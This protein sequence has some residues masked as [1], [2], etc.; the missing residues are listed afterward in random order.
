M[1]YNL[2]M[3]I[4]GK[5]FL[6]TQ[7]MMHWICGSTVVALELAEYLKSSGA[8]VVIYTCFCGEPMK[9][10]CKERGI[11]VDEYSGFPKYKL[12]DFDVVWVHSQI[13]PLSIVEALGKKEL[14]DVPLFVFLHM[15][16]MDWIPDEKPWI[17][18]LENRLSSLS[19]FISEEVKAVNE[20]MIK[21]NIKTDFF[22]NPA[23][24]CFRKRMVAPRE[25][26]RN[27]LIV[28]NHPPQEVEKAGEI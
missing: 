26:V 19:L 28:S 25:Q 11:K 8:E 14:S 22:R 12:G 23:P 7:P 1:C 3:E 13:L 9:G 10:I 15:S 24:E 27:V 5:R 18:D 17:F 2:G 6:I 16:G 21:S 4:K 20:G